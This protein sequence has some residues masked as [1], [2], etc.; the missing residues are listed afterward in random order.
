MAFSFGI[1]HEIAFLEEIIP[2]R[3]AINKLFGA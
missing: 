3:G 1:I 2:R